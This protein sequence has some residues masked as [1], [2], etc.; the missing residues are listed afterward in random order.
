MFS[1]S[2]GV[3]LSTGRLCFWFVGCFFVCFWWSELTTKQ[4]NF[5][6]SILTRVRTAKVGFVDDGSST[7]ISRNMPYPLRRL[8]QFLLCQVQGG[9][10]GARA[11]W[12]VMVALGSEH[13][14][15]TFWRVLAEILP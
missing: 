9:H 13:L 5:L 15:Q 2:E 3:K 12:M 7:C 1:G 10:V 11:T 14:G 4:A 6:S 8:T